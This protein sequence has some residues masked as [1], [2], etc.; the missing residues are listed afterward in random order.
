MRRTKWVRLRIFL[1]ISLVLFAG[2]SRDPNVRK[3][4]YL[5]SGN[6]YFDAGK[7]PEA[8]LQ[9]Q[10]AIQIDPKFAEA[11]EKLADCY[12]RRGIWTGGFQELNRT[13]D[14]EPQNFGAHVKLGNIFMAAH[15]F[16]DA[17]RP[18]AELTVR[19]AT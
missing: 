4:K 18:A 15:Q 12:L 16:K 11:H 14:L 17:L 9:Y 13:I 19:L 10:N 6:K 7:Y 2:C 1:F 5:D 3:Q 8:C